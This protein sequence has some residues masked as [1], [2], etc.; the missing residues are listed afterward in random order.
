M[1]NHPSSPSFHSI[2]SIPTA[3]LPSSPLSRSALRGD[4]G[5][6]GVSDGPL[7]NHLNSTSS[8][9]HRSQSVWPNHNHQYGM[10]PDGEHTQDPMPELESSTRG[11]DGLGVG[12]VGPPSYRPSGLSNTAPRSTSTLNPQPRSP[13]S[14]TPRGSP[15]H[16]STPSNYTPPPSRSNLSFSPSNYSQARMHNRRL[17]SGRGLPP[18]Q[19][20][21]PVPLSDGP[22]QEGSSPSPSPSQS[23]QHSHSLLGSYEESLFAGRMA[24]APSA[25]LFFDAQLGVLGIGKC[26]PSLKCP[27]HLNLKFPA[28]FYGGGS[29][30]ATT[31]GDSPTGLDAT[32]TG[33]EGGLGSPYV[34][35]VDL[36]GHYWDEMLAAH[37]SVAE[38]GQDAGSSIPST[39]NPRD[40]MEQS[41]NGRSSHG[42]PLPSPSSASS[43]PPAFPG[44]RIPPKGQIQLVIKNPNLTAVKLFLVPYDLTDMPAG[45]KTFIRQKCL[46]SPPAP[47][48]VSSSSV[49]SKRA[50][51]KVTK[52]TLRYAIH[53]QLCAVA[54]PSS[55]GT[56][57]GTRSTELSEEKKRNEME[58]RTTRRSRA[59]LPESP[60]TSGASKVASTIKGSPRIY[61]HRDIRV[62]FAPRMPDKEERLT[63]VTEMPG[64]PSISR[65]VSGPSRSMAGDV[66]NGSRGGEGSPG[67]AQE[68]NSSASTPNR[69]KDGMYA[70]YAG[71]G[72]EWNQAKKELREKVKTREKAKL[73][74]QKADGAIPLPFSPDAPEDLA[75]QQGFLS[76]NTI[77]NSDPNG[78]RWEATP[79]EAIET[80]LQEESVL[81]PSPAMISPSSV[82]LGQNSTAAVETQIPSRLQ[83]V[84]LS[85]QSSGVTS[86]GYFNSQLP[87][88]PRAATPIR[89][90]AISSSS[91]EDDNALLD[92]WHQ[93]LLTQSSHRSRPISPTYEAQ[94]EST[95]YT[96]FPSASTSN[97]THSLSQILDPHHSD[98]RHHPQVTSPSL[99][100]SSHH[101]SS[102]SSN[103]LHSNTSNPRSI[104]PISSAS[105]SRGLSIA[106][107]TSH[108]ASSHPWAIGNRSPLLSPKR[109]R[110][111]SLSASSLALSSTEV[112]E[113]VASGHIA[114][115]GP[116]SNGEEFDFQLPQH[117]SL[118]RRISSQSSNGSLNS[119]L[120]DS[121]S[122]LKSLK[123][124]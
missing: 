98:Q 119:S 30:G 49:G 124:D 76:I 61:L 24:S 62:V 100:S 106:G 37:T 41:P 56:S 51:I 18:P 122:S 65:I 35:T 47:V 20:G 105:R 113:A 29:N 88:S 77:V 114:S 16:R 102:S 103:R 95:S 101:S 5:L 121:I 79:E 93:R 94:D 74:S 22:F 63:M 9:F 97:Q 14:S 44:Y 112:S 116:S 108:S 48:D 11:L 43:T 26:L 28:R 66:E 123:L 10:D 21:S 60:S 52:E 91:S 31:T 17:S 3:A 6:S 92:S 50:K 38:L 1:K 111:P 107:S 72:E 86:Q 80:S 85:P 64:G 12:A 40:T 68:N 13:K 120:K 57:S 90:R 34:G 115:S 32:Q 59:S 54:A 84:S 36:E 4:T 27:S 7:S 104:S 25:P 53:L 82:P 81:P 46:A 117:P 67:Q 58:S 96:S 99:S 45:T 55:G 75:L 73:S 118:M 8:E 69:A 71:P 33:L 15:T 110:T 23:L 78:E 109:P 87:Q 89:D 83:S 70:P 2:P 39:V 42:Q 19:L